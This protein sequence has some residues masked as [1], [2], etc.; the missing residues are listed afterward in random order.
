MERDQATKFMHDLLRLML[1]KNGSDLFITADFPPAFKI[2]H[3]GEG[4][5]VMET[6]EL[7]G[8]PA[9]Q[10][11]RSAYEREVALLGEEPEAAFSSSTYGAFLRAHKRALVS[12]RYFPEEW[13]PAVVERVADVT[14]EEI[15]CLFTEE[16]AGGAPILSALVHASAIDIAELR[17]L[18]M[19]ELVADWYCL[20]QGASLAL[21]HIE[22]SRLPVY[23]FLA[24]RFGCEARSR[25]DSSVKGFLAI[26]LGA[27]SLFLDRAENGE[28]Q[29]VVASNPVQQDAPA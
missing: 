22:K 17:S 10:R 28:T 12:H 8:L 9:D 16:S 15:A 23:R 21:P 11:L 13:P 25:H 19:I 5:V 4:S 27:L 14:L 18:P 2:A 20:R 3:P 1:S 24:E 26:F 29:I 6:V 7:S